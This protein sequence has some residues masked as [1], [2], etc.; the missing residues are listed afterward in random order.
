M[1]L[2]G[3]TGPSATV[4]LKSRNME[5]ILHVTDIPTDK[6]SHRNHIPLVAQCVEMSKKKI[7]F[8]RGRH[9]SGLSCRASPRAPTACC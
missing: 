4:F 5:H 1:G 9:R 8:L 6:T 7:N 3:Y 2:R